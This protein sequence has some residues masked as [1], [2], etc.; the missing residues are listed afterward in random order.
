MCRQL[1]A[2]TERQKIGNASNKRRR[3]LQNKVPQ[4]TWSQCRELIVE[5]HSPY[6][7]QRQS[8]CSQCRAN[9]IRG[10]RGIVMDCAYCQRSYHRE[11]LSGSMMNGKVFICFNCLKRCQ[12]RE[13][14][15]ASLHTS[16][17]PGS[18]RKFYTPRQQKRPRQAGPVNGRGE[19]RSSQE[20]SEQSS[21]ITQPDE[22]AAVAKA[23]AAIAAA[24]SKSAT[25]A[26]ENVALP[27]MKK[28]CFQHC[29]PRHH[30]SIY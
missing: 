18:G 21:P 13:R 22:A 11:C 12:Q 15:N 14:E 19:S 17:Q 4:L 10:G 30:Y 1:R 29:L 28:V 20:I 23:A 8:H 7:G 6:K 25:G 5:T 16:Q 24:A 26:I 2:L 3:H 27:A 9:N